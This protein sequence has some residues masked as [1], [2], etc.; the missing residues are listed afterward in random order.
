MTGASIA[1][2]LVGLWAFGAVANPSIVMGLVA[3]TAVILGLQ[4]IFYSFF[5]SILA[6]RTPQSADH[7]VEGPGRS[8]T[9]DPVYGME[10]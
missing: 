5:L 9:H 8:W 4:T 1:T 3:L 2:V 7:V 6:G 10:D